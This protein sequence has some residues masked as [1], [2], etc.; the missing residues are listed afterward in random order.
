LFDPKWHGHL[1]RDSKNP[2][3]QAALHN[4]RDADASSQLP[5]E[6]PRQRT[7]QS[8]GLGK[9][10]GIASHKTLAMTPPPK[11]H[12]HLARDS[13][14]PLAQDALNHRQDADATHPENAIDHATGRS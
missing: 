2:L 11:W 1:A 10:V 9:K 13:K 7:G 14:H 12:G 3:A 5:G 8:S 6:K 4:R